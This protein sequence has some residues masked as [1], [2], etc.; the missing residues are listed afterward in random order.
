ME[1]VAQARRIITANWFDISQIRLRVGHGV[2]HLQGHIQKLGGAAGDHRDMENSLR[3][4][5]DDLR[6]LPGWRGCAYLF[7][8]W[9]Q[10][11]TGGWRHIGHEKDGQQQSG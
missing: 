3:K 5:D 2:V 9:Q 7:D 4:L 11:A 1:I 10:E 8:N 6:T